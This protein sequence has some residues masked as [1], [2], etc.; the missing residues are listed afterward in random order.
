MKKAERAVLTLV[1]RDLTDGQYAALCDFVFNVGRGN[2]EQSALLQ[3]INAGQYDRVPHQFRRWIVAGGKEHIGLRNRRNREIELFFDG[4]PMPKGAP[5]AD[6]DVTPIDI[7]QGEK[8]MPGYP[9]KAGQL[10]VG[11]VR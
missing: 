7:R 11:R 4:I 1:K 9:V 3:A 5:P 6:E 8:V 2:L 10:G